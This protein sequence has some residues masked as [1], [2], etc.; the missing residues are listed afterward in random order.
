[1]DLYVTL[2]YGRRIKCPNMPKFCKLMGNF[3]ISKLFVRQQSFSLCRTQMNRVKRSDF[4]FRIISAH[5]RFV[6]S[7]IN[8][9]DAAVDV[10]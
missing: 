8:Q 6:K 5:F 4:H 3:E 10:V 1:M 7:K 9:W 2:R